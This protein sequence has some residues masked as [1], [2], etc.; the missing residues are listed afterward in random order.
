MKRNIK[1]FFK[2]YLIFLVGILPASYGYSQSATDKP[3]NPV[4][5]GIKQD[6]DKEF[7]KQYKPVKE[8]VSAR[9]RSSKQFKN[10]NGTITYV[11]DSKP[12][13]YQE[14]GQWKEINTD[15]VSNTGIEKSVYSYCNLANDFKTYYASTFNN[16]LK[17]E[18]Q[19]GT[20]IERKESRIAW[21]DI[22]DLEIGD[23]IEANKSNGII[24]SSSLTYNE[25]FNGIDATYIQGC[26]NQELFYIINDQSAFNSKPAN[27][28]YLKIYETV[29]LPSGYSAKLVDG[30]VFKNKTDISKEV[31]IFDENGYPTVTYFP[32]YF[33][34]NSNLINKS[35]SHVADYNISIQGN[36]I[37][38]SFKIPVSWLTDSNRIYPLIIDP[39]TYY[40]YSTSKTAGSVDMFGYAYTSGFDYSDDYCLGIA[41]N[42]W[43]YVWILG[44]NEF[45]LTSLTGTVSNAELDVYKKNYYYGD[46]SSVQVSC[47][48]TKLSARPSLTVDDGVSSSDNSTIYDNIR[49]GTIYG[50]HVFRSSDA[51]GWI[52]ITALASSSTALADIS[53][54]AGGTFSLGYN[55]ATSGTT[56]NTGSLFSDAMNYVNLANWSSTYRPK[57]ILTTC[58][59][60]T[61][62]TAGS[63]QELCTVNQAT[64]AATLGT[65]STGAWTKVGSATGT[66]QSPTSAT[67]LITGIGS[68]ANTYRWTVTNSG[69][70]TAYDDVIIT[71]NIPT[72]AN[73]GLDATTCILP[74]TLSGNSP[75]TGCTGVWTDVTSGGAAIFDNSKVYNTTVTNLKTPPSTNTLRWTIKKGGCTDYDEVNITYNSKPTASISTPAA[76]PYSTCSSSQSLAAADPSPATGEW[77]VTSGSGTISNYTSYNSASVSGLSS[78]NNVIKWTVTASGNGCV[79]HDNVTINYKPLTATAGPD[80]YITSTTATLAGNNPTAPAT[81]TWTWVGSP[82]A[83]I[84]TPSAYN[85]GVTGL[86]LGNYTLKWTVSSAGC[87]D[88]SDEV[89]LFCTPTEKGLIISDNLTNLTGSFIDTDDPNFFIMNG[90]SKFINGENGTYTN[91]KLFVKGTITFDGS[92]AVGK[93]DSTK[94]DASRFFT[95]YNSRTYKNGRLTNNGTVTMNTGSVWENSEDWHNYGT[96]TLAAS[97]TVK[98]N[99]DGNCTSVPP[100]VRGYQEV[101]SKISTSTNVFGNVEIANTQNPP[102]DTTTTTGV[103]LRDNMVLQDASNL[104]FTDGV[105]V[106]GANKVIVNNTANTAVNY[107]GANSD[108]AS[109]WVYGTIRRYLADA[110]NGAHVFP[111]GLANRPNK[112]ILTNNSLPNASTFYLDCKFRAVP[113][114]IATNFPTGLSECHSTY[115]SV[116]PEG[117]WSIS[118]T[119]TIDGT[120]DLKLYF[121]GFG[122][123]SP[124][125]DYKFGIITRPSDPGNGSTWALASGNCVPTTV[126]SG[127]VHRSGCN[128]FSEE[129][130]SEKGIGKSE[131]PLP[132]ELLYFT[133]SCKNR[134]IFFKW[135]T[136]SETN[137]DYFLIEKKINNNWKKITKVNGNGNTN[138]IS[139][140]T[141]FDIN[142]S[143]NTLNGSETSYYRLKQTDYNGNYEAFEPIPITCDEDKMY[144]YFNAYLDENKNIL[145]SFSSTNLNQYT[146]TLI[147]HYGK[148]IKE[149]TGDALEGMNTAALSVSDLSKEIYLIVLVKDNE[150]KIKKILVQ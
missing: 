10:E 65:A 93:F 147:D 108:Y 18:L 74:Y 66:L 106:T 135:A 51:N 88:A 149:I 132:V 53:A 14:N 16:G 124:T 103:L 120:Y 105:L 50:N 80:Q 112:A 101:Y 55:A 102:A 70:C 128:T 90:T 21:S 98:F 121:N 78:G 33:Y 119:G 81:G 68:G 144:D 4:L 77:S 43:N 36:N 24:S 139:E 1:Q 46:F 91:A 7:W 3:A 143:Q 146:I 148:K 64:M 72:D 2:T 45:D 94:V 82:T 118:K 116:D 8:I 37:I 63:D 136:A 126:A 42:G 47:N 67:T 26:D 85:S 20:F 49:N 127:Y 97:S 142:P 29:V 69:G 86:S 109:S 141:A 129:G 40:N 5:S 134:N 57:L 138:Y 52:A 99:G 44:W 23:F 131:N 150:H 39:T 137:N 54:A 11:A 30:R 111:V 6:A 56:D 92:I 13:H 41:Y 22:N 75:E 19:S 140:Y 117:V 100:T 25:V 104:T 12:L 83:S 110:N 73:A 48:L 145:V 35:N 62:F 115:Q 31:V 123:V 60:P 58:T 89:I 87:S 27:A 114:Y 125:D 38:I 122:L 113:A 28:A 59:A 34:D 76:D 79:S 15:I 96:Q 9:T 107:G 95:V 133:A 61:G 71:N 130:F 84:T 17:V 32:V